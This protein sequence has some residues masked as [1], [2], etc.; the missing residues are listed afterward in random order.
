[1]SDAVVAIIAIPVSILAAMLLVA[2][3]LLV[4]AKPSPQLV[5][6]HTGPHNYW[7]VQP[8]QIDHVEG[9]L[10]AEY[11]P[12][13]YANRDDDDTT[14]VIYTPDM[15]GWETTGR[16]GLDSPVRHQQVPTHWVPPI[17]NLRIAILETMTAEYLFVKKPKDSLQPQMVRPYMTTNLV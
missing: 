12:R 11:K 15:E 6:R 10:H 3:G 16:R 2:I 14:D 8:E 5:R 7:S 1:M 13:R 9:V 4:T 17:G